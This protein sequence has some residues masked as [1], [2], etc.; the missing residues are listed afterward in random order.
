MV[1]SVIALLVSVRASSHMALL[2]GLTAVGLT[3][4]SV[5]SDITRYKVGDL[6]AVGC[7]VHSCQQCDQCH[8]GEEQFCREG[9][10]QTFR[11]PDRMTGQITTGGYS[12][13]KPGIRADQSRFHPAGGEHR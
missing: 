9:M 12:N 7:M 1:Q 4:L 11:S 5:G 3:S 6:V 2:V 10:R 8:A 13:S